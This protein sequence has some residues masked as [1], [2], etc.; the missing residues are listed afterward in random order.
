MGY[1]PKDAVSIALDELSLEHRRDSKV[2]QR[3]EA[4]AEEF[5]RR[6]REGLI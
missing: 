5:L 6:V 1:K 4:E 3:A 2:M